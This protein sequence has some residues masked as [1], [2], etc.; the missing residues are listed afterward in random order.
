[1]LISV[2]NW[3]KSRVNRVDGR[4]AGPGLSTEFEPYLSVI[5]DRIRSSVCGM[6]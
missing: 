2:R 3:Q 5:V 4:M 1:M 6:V